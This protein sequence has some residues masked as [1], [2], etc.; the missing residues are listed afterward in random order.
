[1][2]LPLPKVVYDVGPGGGVVTGMRGANALTASGLENQIKQSDAQYAPYTNYANALSHLAYAQTAPANAIAQI[3]SGPAAANMSAE[4]YQ[5]LAQQAQTSLGNVNTNFVPRPGTRQEGVGHNLLRTLFDKIIPGNNIFSQGG[6]NNNSAGGSDNP[7]NYPQTRTDFTP[8]DPL[9]SGQ[10]NSPPPNSPPQNSPTIGQGRYGNKA[11]GLNLPGTMGGNT[12]SAAAKTQEAVL[13]AG[14]TGEATSQVQQQD[15]MEKSDAAASSGAV[16]MINQISKLKDARS[17]LGW[18]E[19]GYPLGKG[20]GV[21]SPAQEFDQAKENIANTIAKAEQTGH[22]NVGDREIANS[23]KPGRDIND[24]AFNH[25]I[26]YAEGASHRISE[27]PAFD[28]AMAASGYAPAETQTLWSYYG[29]RKPFFNSKEH[30][31]DE[32]NLNSWEDFYKGKNNKNREAAFSPS[33]QKAINKANAKGSYL[34]SHLSQKEVDRENIKTEGR[35]A[36]NGNV[37]MVRPDGLRVPVHEE[38]VEVAKQKYHYQE[39]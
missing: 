11:S 38:N 35:E 18:Y 37:W 16:E 17:R 27:K 23:M 30:K 8:V 24:E 28:R 39:S 29:L 33:A 5:Q 20:P 36:P 32:D 12:P 13:N 9:G 25:L 3:L 1:M 7:M 19:K 2:S 34:S 4:R 10:T 15:A 14:A 22:I 21:T 6:G 26:D 31:Q